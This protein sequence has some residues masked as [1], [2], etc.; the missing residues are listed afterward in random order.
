MLRH[1]AMIQCARI[2]FGFGGIFDPDEAERIVERDITAESEVVEP[3]HEGPPPYPAAAFAENLPKWAKL[4]ESGRKAPSDIIAM[5]STKG[6]LSDEQRA[7]I[8][9][10]GQPESPTGEMTEEERQDAIARERAEAGE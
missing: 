7:S 4:I 3:A 5:A 8:N 2:A 9:A 1:K 6:T 10:A